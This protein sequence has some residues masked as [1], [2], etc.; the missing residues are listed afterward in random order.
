MRKECGFRTALSTCFPVIYPLIDLGKYDTEKGKNLI[1]I[2]LKKIH[3]LFKFKK[4]RR[5]IS[6]F[7][8]SATV[9]NQI[10]TAKQKTPK[11]SAN[12]RNRD[13]QFR[14]LQDRKSILSPAN[15]TSSPKS[16]KGN[17]SWDVTA[18][19]VPPVEDK[20]RFHDLDLPLN[21]MHAIADLDFRYCTPIQ[22]GI[23]PKALKGVDVTGQ[24]QTGTGKS[25][26]F[27]ITLLTQLIQKPPRSKRQKGTPRALI[28][29]PT[30]ELVLQIEKDAK[31]LAKYLHFRIL[32]VFGGMGYG[33][34]KEILTH[35]LVDIVV[36]TPGR[37]IDFK[38]QGIVT[39]N[40][41][42]FLV[43]DEAD[44]MLDMGFI[45]DIRRIIHSTPPKRERQTMFFS[46]TLTP[47]ATRLASQWTDNSFN[48]EIEPEQVASESIDQIIYIVTSE[49]KFALLYNMITLQ[50]LK[51][52]IIFANRRDETRNLMKKLEKYDIDCA[53]LSGEVPQTKRLRALENFKAGKIRVLVATDVAARGIHVE[54][55]SHVINYNLPQD[56]EHY[57]HRIGRTGRAGATGTSISFACEEDSFHIPAIEEFLGHEMRCQYPDEALLS[58]LPA[59]K[60]QA[61]QKAD[62]RRYPHSRNRKRSPQTKSYQ[63]SS[64]SKPKNRPSK[65]DSRDPGRKRSNSGQGKAPV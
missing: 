35:E 55:V 36:A 54:D 27:L 25:A 63:R 3:N 26:A 41:I 50:N 40:K 20:T 1:Q 6:K 44:R 24:A 19:E 8:D 42:E 60:E 53:L 21:L 10:E 13:K 51:R 5:N 48:V 23:L 43:I 58:A 30:R 59:P 11:L 17:V 56:P 7:N 61:P 18:F 57:V 47:D 65:S 37:L 46:A 4:T 64:H 62:R 12:A 31:A 15:K 49:E 14:N 32:A 38:N 28:L 16:G 39:L 29:A 2:L 9:I 45:P 33:K 52:V 34:Q 22:A